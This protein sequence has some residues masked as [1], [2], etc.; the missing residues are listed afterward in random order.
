MSDEFSAAGFAPEH[1]EDLAALG[2]QLVHQSGLPTTLNLDPD[3][4]TSTSTIEDLVKEVALKPLRGWTTRWCAAARRS[5]PRRSM[6]C[7]PNT[8]ASSAT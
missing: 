4:T 7:V 2:L 3:E 5:T 1:V 8:R 6:Y